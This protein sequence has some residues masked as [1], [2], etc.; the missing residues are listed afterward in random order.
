MFRRNLTALLI[1]LFLPFLSSYTFSQDYIQDTLTIRA[2]LDSNGLDT[3]SVESVSDSGGGRIVK[4]N[5]F[6]K[7]H[8]Y[9]TEV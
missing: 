3:L 6:K 9:P 2:I 4:L 5:L 1:F 8:S 7:N